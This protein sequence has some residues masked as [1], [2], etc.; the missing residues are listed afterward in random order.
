MTPNNNQ[1]AKYAIFRYIT[2]FMLIHV[3]FASFKNYKK[4]YVKY[5]S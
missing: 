5:R 4:I 3:S 2:V 1:G